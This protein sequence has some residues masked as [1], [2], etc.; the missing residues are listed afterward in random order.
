V[1][2]RK[3]V[4]DLSTH[5]HAYIFRVSQSILEKPNPENE[6]GT[7]IYRNDGKYSIYQS[8]YHNIPGDIY[9]IDF[10]ANLRQC[11]KDSLTDH[12]AKD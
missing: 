10:P 6:A 7:T 11:N 4:A 12:G 3:Y 2:T 1:S 5:F 9:N 8:T